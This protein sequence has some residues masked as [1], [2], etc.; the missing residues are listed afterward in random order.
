MTGSRWGTGG[1]SAA[2]ESFEESH[3]VMT[4]GDCDDDEVEEEEEEDLGVVS[5]DLLKRSRSFWISGSTGSLGAWEEVAVDD[6]FVDGLVGLDFPVSFG[7][8]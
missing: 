6:G 2:V 5:S 7:T 8:E 4:E 3:D 1:A